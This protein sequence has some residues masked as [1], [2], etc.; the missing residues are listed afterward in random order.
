MDAGGQDNSLT[1]GGPK[2]LGHDVLPDFSFEPGWRNLNHGESADD[3]ADYCNT[4]L[5]SF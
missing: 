3:R 2:Q 1:R 4:R 5:G